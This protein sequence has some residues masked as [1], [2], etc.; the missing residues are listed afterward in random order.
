MQTAR[1]QKQQRIAN[2]SLVV[3]SGIAALMLVTVAVAIRGVQ[4]VWLSWVLLTAAIIM[5]VASILVLRASL[6]ARGR[7]GTSDPSA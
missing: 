3:M 6:A 4:T 7:A 5:L 2:V 1:T